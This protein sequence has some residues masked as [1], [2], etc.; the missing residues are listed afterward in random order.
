V[1][2]APFEE[3]LDPDRSVDAILAKVRAGAGAIREANV[4]AFSLPPIIG[5][6]T[7]GGFEYQLQDL[8]AAHPPISPPPCA[9][10]SSRPTSSRSCARLQHLCRQYAAALSRHRPQQGADARRFRER[11]LPGAAGHARRLLRERLQPFGRTWQVNIQGELADRGKVTDIYRINVRNKQGDMVPLRSL[12][13]A[14]I[15]LAP[16]SLTRYNNY[17]S[18]TVNGENGPGRS[19]GEALATMERISK[20]TLPTGYGYAWTGT[21]QQEKEA[22]GQTPK[23]LGLAILFAFLFLVASTRAGTFRFPSCC[24]SPSACS[25]L[26]SRC[27]SP[28]S[29]TISMRRSA[30][31]C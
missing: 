22:A 6:G 17:R 23:I 5:L 14:H 4:L 7:T 29:A 31:S 2:L 11:H 9:G 3:R 30:S 21:A 12:A 16:Q 20:E 8:T 24:R 13:D 10:S 25:A 26:C 27:W 19:T 18:V 28:V 1:T 15:I